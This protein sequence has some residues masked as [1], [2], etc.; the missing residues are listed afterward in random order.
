MNY[1]ENSLELRN[2][3]QTFTFI[4]KYPGVYLRKLSRSLDIPKTTL[5]YHL[6]YLEKRGYI[7]KKQDGKYLRYY[8]TEN[9]GIL[10]KKLLHLF[11][12]E[13]SR[14][15]IL[16]LLLKNSPPERII[17][18]LKYNPRTI[19]SNLK[20]LVE[21]DIVTRVKVFNQIQ[22]RLKD[23]EMIV[24]F[25]FKYKDNLSNDRIM[26][27]YGIMEV[28]NRIEYGLPKKGIDDVLDII[29]DVFPHPYH[30]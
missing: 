2:R 10:E 20:K 6:D 18:K 29:F 22:Y 21:M 5:I 14:N 26:S 24:D 8:V 19:N 3:R 27:K 4:R 11:R 12:Q 28:L 9:V 7:E 23:P 13:S 1:S 17:S 15:I 25:L 16:M 30:A